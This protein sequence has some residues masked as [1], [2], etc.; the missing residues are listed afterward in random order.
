MVFCMDGQISQ[1]CPF[2]IFF[3]FNLFWGV[4]LEKEVSKI[5]HLLCALT[6]HKISLPILVSLSLPLPLSRSLF[7]LIYQGLQSQILKQ[8]LQILS[9]SKPPASSFIQP[10]PSWLLHGW[11]RWLKAVSLSAWAPGARRCGLD[12]ALRQRG[13]AVGGLGRRRL[14]RRR[15]MSCGLRWLSW[16]WVDV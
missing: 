11:W 7:P 14:A 2:R 16:S 4:K 5:E 13:E 3:A 12:L 1:W 9:Q 15:R 10:N 6:L 8:G